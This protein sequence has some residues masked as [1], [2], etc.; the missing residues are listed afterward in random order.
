M[1]KYSN[2]YSHS[3]IVELDGEDYLVQGSINDE[4]TMF[5]P[6]SELLECERDNVNKMLGELE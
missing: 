6:I 2:D 3:H 4:L 5:R 1:T